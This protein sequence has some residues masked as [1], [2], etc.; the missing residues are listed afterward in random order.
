LCGKF[1]KGRKFP[2]DS[3]K[4]FKKREFKEKKRNP[5]CSGAHGV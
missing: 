5:L 1:G 4:F 2:R 3:G